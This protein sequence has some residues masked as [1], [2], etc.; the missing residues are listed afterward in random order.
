MPGTNLRF[1][2]D[3]IAGLVPGVGDLL[4]A[5][6]SCAILIEAHRSRVPRVVQL[7]MLFNTALDLALGVVPVVGDV[8]DFV[9]KSNAR[10]F[11]LLER[12]AL[13][14]TRPSL[15]DW[16]FVGAVLL[17]LALVALAPLLVMYW[18]YLSL[19]AR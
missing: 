8:G 12:H 1:G 14:P 13:A 17:V 3:P 18:L 2:W 15:A 4:T 9:W 11:A 6:L 10:N 7:R 16:I 19:A 5:V